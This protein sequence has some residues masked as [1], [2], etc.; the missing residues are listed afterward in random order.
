MQP[1]EMA[2]L[3]DHIAHLQTLDMFS[4]SDHYLQHASGRSCEWRRVY[5]RNVCRF[6]F[7]KIGN[8]ILEQVITDKNTEGFTLSSGGADKVFIIKKY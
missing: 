3:D 4:I 1:K 7:K 2:C 5:I 8:L 6:T